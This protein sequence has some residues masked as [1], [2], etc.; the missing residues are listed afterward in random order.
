MAKDKYLC[1][2]LFSLLSFNNN[3][4]VSPLGSSDVSVKLSYITIII[5]CW[6]SKTYV[7][8]KLNIDGW[9]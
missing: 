7:R 5:L 1:M 8:T 6:H 9:K 2:R 4:H 3:F